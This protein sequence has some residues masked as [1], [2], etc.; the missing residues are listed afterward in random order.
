MEKVYNRCPFQLGTGRKGC[1]DY[2]EKEGCFPLV[3]QERQ[4]LL[5]EI[6]IHAVV[7]QGLDGGK[8]FKGVPAQTGHFADQERSHLVFQA[9]FHGIHQGRTFL[10]PL[11]SADMFLEHP[12]K[13]Q[14]PVLRVLVQILNLSLGALAVPG[15][16]HPRVDD[17]RLV[18]S[19]LHFNL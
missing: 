14:T 17:R 3:I 4:L 19:C 9:E 2:R 5:L 1:D 13:I 15:A 12:Y 18:L 10:V 11:R 7:G 6:E 8:H 16:R